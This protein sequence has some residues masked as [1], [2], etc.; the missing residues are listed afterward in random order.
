MEWDS[1]VGLIT[2]PLVQHSAYGAFVFFAVFSLLSGAWTWFVVPETT[3]RSLEDMDEIWG[4]DSGRRD[5]ERTLAV[6]SRLER[7][8]AERHSPVNA[9][10]ASE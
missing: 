8:L 9:M 6:V 7:E 5:K 4:D 3:G 1:I 2:P 10:Q